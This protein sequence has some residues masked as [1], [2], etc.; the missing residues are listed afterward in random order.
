MNKQSLRRDQK[1][2]LGGTMDTFA[3]F[4]TYLNAVISNKREQLTRFDLNDVLTRL[5]ATIQAVTTTNLAAIVYYQQWPMLIPN[6]AAGG[7][8][9]AGT[10]SYAI[11]AHMNGWQLIG[12][13]IVVG[14]VGGTPHTLK[15]EA[16]DATGGYSTSP[17]IRA[18]AAFAAGVDNTLLEVPC[19]LNTGDKVSA[20]IADPGSGGTKDVTIMFHFNNGT[21]GA[22]VATW[23]L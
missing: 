23:P 18:A 21:D 19:I 2:S 13:T 7:V 11:P 16:L 4:I 17:D 20:V 14:T 6:V 9:E 1:V 10:Y 15:L 3:K 22:A 8:V 12:Y 5:V